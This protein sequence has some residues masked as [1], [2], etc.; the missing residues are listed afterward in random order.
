MTCLRWILLAGLLALTG[1]AGSANTPSMFLLDSGDA[2]AGAQRIAAPVLIVDP[3]TV[4]SFLDENG[5]VYQT[6]PHRV[7]M[8]N[9]NRW[10]SPLAGQLT[11]GLYNALVA[12]LDDVSV[13]RGGHASSA[14]A[15][16]LTTHVDQFMGHYDGQAHIGGRW[17]LVGP[18][19]QTAAGRRFERRIPL[20]SDGYDALVDSLSRGWRQTADD[21]AGV[22]EPILDEPAAR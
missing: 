13:Q 3:V 21:M 17:A 5:I 11:G 9:N 18:D 6:G 19:G 8:A 22:V 1:C 16:H 14:Q 20:S 12:R 15:W 4:A 7:V 2:G 10:A